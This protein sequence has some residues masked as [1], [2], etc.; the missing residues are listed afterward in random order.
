MC[1][2]NAVSL[3]VETTEG[4]HER[5]EYLDIFFLPITQGRSISDV[6]FTGGMWVSDF[7]VLKY[8]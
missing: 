8:Y 6:L 4:L 7:S 5:T 1:L 3:W 2:R